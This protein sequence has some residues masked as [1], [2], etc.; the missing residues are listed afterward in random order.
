[1]SRIRRRRAWWRPRS[2]GALLVAMDQPA[3]DIAELLAVLVAIAVAWLAMTHVLTL[4][5]VAGSLRRHYAAG[6]IGAVGAG[7]RRRRCW[8]AADVRVAPRRRDASA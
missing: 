4:R 2:R 7:A 5:A 8:H 3:G 1:M 6:V